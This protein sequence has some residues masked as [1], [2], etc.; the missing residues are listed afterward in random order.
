MPLSG[1]VDGEP[2]VVACSPTE[3]WAHLKEDV[4]AKRRGT[5]CACGWKG[6]AKTSKLGTA[7]F[8][9]APGGDGCSAGE[10]AQHLRAKAIIVEAITR[11]GWTAQ[12]EVP[13]DG[14]VADVMATRGDVRVVFEVQWS[15]PDPRRVRDTVSSRYL[16]S[17]IAAIAWFARHADDLPRA[18]KQ[19]P[20]F[21]LDIDEEAR[22]PSIG[23]TR[24]SRS[25]RRWTVC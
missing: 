18:D 14:W 5:R 23:G 15:R 21:G 3:E 11:A 22:P 12:T 6:L 4:R 9:H 1:L 17:G 16:D 24:S 25:P 2:V 19:L 20:V 8:A 7:Y 10:S 13:G